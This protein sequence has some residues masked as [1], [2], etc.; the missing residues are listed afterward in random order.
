MAT[1]AEALAL[2]FDHHQAGSLAEAEQI[3]RRILQTEPN[4]ADALHLLGVLAHQ[5]GRPTEAIDLLNRAIAA[6][7]SNSA[8]YNHLGAVYGT[9]GRHDEAEASF[10]QALRLAPNDAESHY[11]LAALLVMR[12]RAVEAI[13]G[14]RQA[15]R[16]NPRFVHAYFNLGNLL[17]IDGNLS[18]ADLAEAVRCYEKALEIKPDYVSALVNLGNVLHL[19]DQFDRASE[20]LR[21]AIQIKPDTTNAINNLGVVLLDQGRLADAAAQFEHLTRLKPDFAEGHNNLGV[22]LMKLGRLDESLFSLKRA[23]ELNPNYADARKNRAAAWLLA[24]DFERGWPEY[25]WRWKSKEAAPHSHRQPLWDGAPLDGRTIL[26]HSEQGLGDTLQFI[27]YAPSVKA[28]GGTVV[29]SCPG[30]LIPLLSPCVGIDRLLDERRVAED[31]ALVADDV[32]APLMSLPG[33]LG[34]TRSTIPAAIPYL[35]AEPKLVELWRK[36]LEPVK[37]LRVGVAWQGRR[38]T[39]KYR[40]DAQRSIPLANFEPLA[41]VEGVELFS[42]QKGQ[43]LAEIRAL[44]ERFRVAEIEGLDETA[45]AFMDTAAVMVNLDLV[46]TADTATAHLAGALGVPVW[47]GIPFAPDWRWELVGESTPWYPTM[48]L[49]RQTAWGDWKSVLVRMAE[50]LAQLANQRQL[51]PKSSEGT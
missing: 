48:R 44:A 5:T 34:T 28:R 32:Q 20:Y 45:G 12:G 30:G 18:D 26:L 8:F 21:R 23:I 11:N 3:Y 33:I 39:P 49:F 15:I 41:K 4:H 38:R 51:N 7:A 17:G 1:V 47:V 13:A 42:L 37:T 6:N 14:Y 10:R 25:E 29:L 50:E 40:G 16:L 35:F 46:V 27:R 24:G 31:P 2:A 22:A 36:R 19:L 43:A 9:V